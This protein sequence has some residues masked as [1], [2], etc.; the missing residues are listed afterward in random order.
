MV[1]KNIKKPVVKKKLVSRKKPLKKSSLKK[2][3]VKK[4]IQKT[5]VKKILI[6][7]TETPILKKEPITKTKE[8]PHPLKITNDPFVK[9][10]LKKTGF[11]RYTHGPLYIVILTLIMMFFFEMFIY[12]KYSSVELVSL[13]STLFMPFM[14]IITLVCLFAFMYLGYKGAQHNFLFNKMFSIVVNI[15]LLI[16]IVE[17]ILT[18]IGFMTF[19]VPFVVASFESLATQKLYL[20]YLISWIFVKS[21]FYL[22]M[23]AL[24]YLVF[25]KLRFVKY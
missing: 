10:F 14:V 12:T 20:F 5:T 19:L 24:S 11:Y 7:K 17:I 2:P 9:G 22:F 1:A 4:N 16:A 6:T 8:K 18:F 3:V 21:V 23:T 15:V 13:K 25:Y